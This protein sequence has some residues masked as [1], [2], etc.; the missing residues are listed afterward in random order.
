MTK[1]QVCAYENEAGAEYC[2]E[3]GVRIG[4]TPAPTPP[5]GSAAAT[6]LAAGLSVAAQPAPEVEAGGAPQPGCI[7]CHAPLPDGTRFCPKCG[8]KQDAP[9]AT[10]APSGKCPSCGLDADP[11]AAFCAGCGARVTAEPIAPPKP[12]GEVI[13]LRMV[14]GKDKDKLFEIER[15][16]VRI[17]RLNE[18]DIPLEADG[19]VSG[20]HTRISKQG[21]EFFVEDLGSTNGTFLKVRK[22]TRLSPGDEIKVGQSIFRLE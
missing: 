1:C 9:A 19:Y 22:L 12:K 14:A 10:A 6:P 7:S 3:C 5:S 17:G 2:E 8:A 15:N 20:K 11:G 4:G 13:R 18:N 21:G 16:E